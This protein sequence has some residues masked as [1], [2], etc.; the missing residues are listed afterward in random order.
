MNIDKTDTSKF[1]YDPKTPESYLK[2]K[3]H[4]E[5]KA[6]LPHTLPRERIFQY[7]IWMYDRASDAVRAE[8]PLYTQ[9]KREVARMVGLI[10]GTKNRGVE[11]VLIGPNDSVNIMIVKYIKMFNSP[12][13][14]K[15]AIYQEISVH[16]QRKAI[17]GD[18]DK[19]LIDN[20]EK[21]TD[22][23]KDLEVN[24]FYG[25]DETELR[26]ELYRTIEDEDLGVTSEQIAQ[27]LA[28]GQ[29]PL[30]GV[31]LYGAGYKPAKMKFIGDK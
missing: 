6:S 13:Y 9:R 2:L 12:E 22:A 28:K 29:D 25:K 1:L 14:S 10:G 31:D 3:E 20:V 30:K 17:S 8:Y 16:L 21:I 5:F 26:A 7:I 11:N 23:I 27:K 18:I 4:Q 19:A 24:V 15:L